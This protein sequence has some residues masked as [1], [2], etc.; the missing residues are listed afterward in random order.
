MIE[1]TD[2][3]KK[4][5]SKVIFEHF[6]MTIQKG[7]MI[8]VVG[9]SGAGKSTLLNILGLIDAVDSGEYHFED[10][11]NVKPNSALAQ[12][13][14]Q[15]KIS[16]LFQNFALV[17][18]ATVAENLLLALKYVHQTKVA[19]QNLIA[20]ALQK[21]GLGNS[22]HNKIYE[23]SGGQQQRVAIARAVVKPSELVLADEPTG[24]LDD[25][26]RDEIIKLLGE[27]NDAGKTVVIVTHDKRVAQKCHRIISLG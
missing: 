12:K 6:D 4:F 20:A 8:A 23:L 14:I 27:L 24:S 5:G 16:Y 13:I 2:V 25:Q 21:V 3:T 22:L 15:M 26:N 18:E 7:E 17:E 19:K 9:P 10:K 1:L 11:V